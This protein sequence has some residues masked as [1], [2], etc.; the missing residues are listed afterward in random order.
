MEKE[1]RGGRKEPEEDHGKLEECR[2][3]W[4]ETKPQQTAEKHGSCFQGQ[5]ETQALQQP[6]HMTNCP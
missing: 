6:D 4:E 5:Y 1:R 2:K 3:Q